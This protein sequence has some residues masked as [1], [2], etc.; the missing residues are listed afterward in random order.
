MDQSYACVI[1]VAG[2]D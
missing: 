1:M 2:G